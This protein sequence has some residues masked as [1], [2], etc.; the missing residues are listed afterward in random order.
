MLGTGTPAQL[1]KSKKIWNEQFQDLKIR[2]T[3][4]HSH[5]RKKKRKK[6]VVATKA[7]V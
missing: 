5:N 7:T 4:S 3:Q 1:G 2:V 6:L